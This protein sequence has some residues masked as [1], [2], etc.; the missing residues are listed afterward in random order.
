M[1]FFRMLTGGVRKKKMCGEGGGL[2]RIQQQHN[3]L[4]LLTPHFSASCITTTT[5]VKAD[6]EWQTSPKRVQS[7]D[8]P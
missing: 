2:Y 1:F 4:V 5:Q 6:K 7:V 8:E 3:I